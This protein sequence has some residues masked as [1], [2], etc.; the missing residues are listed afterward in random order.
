MPDRAAKE[1]KQRE[2]TERYQSAGREGGGEKEK[3]ENE[4]HK[5]K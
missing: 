2:H 5:R 4:T 3:H 1:K